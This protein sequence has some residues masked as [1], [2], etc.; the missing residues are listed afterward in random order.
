MVT[1][2][3]QKITLLFFRDLNE[4][5]MKLGNQYFLA[6]T[7]IAVRAE[8][9]AESNGVLHDSGDISWRDLTRV[10]YFFSGGPCS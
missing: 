6:H 3:S 5:H 2:L 1:A 10:L 9:P 7:V 8:M 4:R